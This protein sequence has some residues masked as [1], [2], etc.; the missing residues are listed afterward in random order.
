MNAHAHMIL[1]LPERQRERERE[2]RLEDLKI[3]ILSH[4][5]YESSVISF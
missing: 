2:R 4:A 1:E 5:G 3:E